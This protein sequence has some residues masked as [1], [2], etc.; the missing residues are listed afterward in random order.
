MNGALK[1]CD[2]H[3]ENT[4]KLRENI[5]VDGKSKET[6]W[7]LDVYII[8]PSNFCLSYILNLHLLVSTKTILPLVCTVG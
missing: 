4:F 2:S 3:L 5:I 7:R 6:T 8:D 1:L